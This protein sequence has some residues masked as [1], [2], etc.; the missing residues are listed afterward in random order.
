MKT[1]KTWLLSLSLG[2]LCSCST[3]TL[4]KDES[5]QV[6]YDQADAVA[7]VELVGEPTGF[8]GEFEVLRTWKGEL[9]QRISVTGGSDGRGFEQGR[10]ILYLHHQEN[11]RFGSGLAA[12]NVHESNGKT[13]YPRLREF[14]KS[15][16]CGCKGYEK[17]G[18]DRQYLYERADLI[19]RAVVKRVRKRG[20]FT[21][22]DLEIVGFAKPLDLLIKQRLADDLRPPELL[23]VITAEE[24]SDCG[25]PATV[26]ASDAE[27]AH[28]DDPNYYLFH[29]HAVGSVKTRDQEASLFTG[30]CSG[31]LHIS[32]G[33]AWGDF[34][35]MRRISKAANNN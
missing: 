21:Y 26:E 15:I 13:F 30:V 35:Q 18:F 17:G 14:E 7:L 8:S 9:P 34:R 10:Y 23:T 27:M 25:Y 6:S 4:R 22:A 33:M 11:G 31:N 19:V 28:D 12:W 1:I 2:L 20:I 29:L 3:L 5:P 24:G 16:E 32:E